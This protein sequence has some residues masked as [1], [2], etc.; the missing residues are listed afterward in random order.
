MI[1]ACS[2]SVH[3]K[4]ALNS[5]PTKLSMK[6]ACVYQL[7]ETPA[8]GLCLF[9][10]QLPMYP[11]EEVDGTHLFHAFMKVNYVTISDNQNGLQYHKD[12]RIN[13]H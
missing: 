3:E 1:E 5:W 6:Y 11:C 2:I 9:Q 13:T 7:V 4:P 10:F 12:A 8:D